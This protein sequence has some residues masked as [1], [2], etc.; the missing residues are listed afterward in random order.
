MEWRTGRISSRPEGGPGYLTKLEDGK[1]YA[2]ETDAD[3]D[4]L[5]GFPKLR[6]APFRN[7]K[8]AQR[9]IEDLYTGD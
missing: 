6:E 5:Q 4:L 9:W 3:G 7:L 2:Y 8:E 1:W